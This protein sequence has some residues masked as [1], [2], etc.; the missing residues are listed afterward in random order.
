MANNITLETIQSEIQQRK[1]YLQPA[2]DEYS[3][4]ERALTALN[5]ITETPKRSY[6]RR[7]RNNKQTIK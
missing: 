4:L 5:G 2:A 7:G 3:R 6:K 1:A